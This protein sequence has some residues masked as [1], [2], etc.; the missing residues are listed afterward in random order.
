MQSKPH[1]PAE[2]NTEYYATRPNKSQIKRD[3]A[4]NAKLAEQL[5]ALSA[6]QLAKVRLPPD[7]ATALADAKRATAAA[8]HRKRQLKFITA[9]LGKIA[10]D[11]VI[12]T[13]AKLQTKGMLETARHHR[14]EKL[15][16]KLLTHGKQALTE[17]L[18]Q[19]PTA[20]RQYLHQLQRN[21]Q[22]EHQLQK[23]PK[24]AKILYR[25]LQELID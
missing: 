22:K 12:A 5:L 17:A 23:P 18:A 16:D 20:N 25:Y 11:E 13:L 15:R 6:A 1:H 8:P 14:I 2:A 24:S 10:L 19:V 4:S 21:A 3:I 7:I 9:Q